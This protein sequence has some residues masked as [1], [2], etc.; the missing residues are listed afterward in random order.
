MSELKKECENVKREEF[1]YPRFRVNDQFIELMTDWNEEFRATSFKASRPVSKS[2]RWLTERTLLK[3]FAPAAVVVNELGNILFIHGQTGMFLEPVPGYHGISNVLKMSRVGLRRELGIALKEAVDQQK[4]IY[5][6]EISIKTLG[7]NLLVNMTVG[8][9]ENSNKEPALYIIIFENGA[10]FQSQGT[11]KDEKYPINLDE[12]MNIQVNKDEYREVLK[13]ERTISYRSQELSEIESQLQTNSEMLEISKRELETFCEVL[14]NAKNDIVMNEKLIEISNENLKT[15]NEKLISDRNEWQSNNL[16]LEVSNEELQRVNEKLALCKSDFEYQNRLLQKASEELKSI[17]EKLVLDKSELEHKEH[18]LSAANEELQRIEERLELGKS[19][20]EDKKNCIKTVEE[21]LRI[22]NERSEI[23]KNELER[24]ALLLTESK[25]KLQSVKDKLVFG[26]SE[27]KNNERLLEKDKEELANL[28]DKLTFIKSELVNQDSLLKAAKDELKIVNEQVGSSRN[29]LRINDNLFEILKNEIETAKAELNSV[30]AE[31]AK[32]NELPE[33]LRQ[34]LE[35]IKSE[36]DTMKIELKQTNDELYSA[37][38]QL[39]R[40]NEEIEKSKLILS[41]LNT[42]LPTTP[43]KVRENN[44]SS[45]VQSLFNDEESRSD[46]PYT[47]LSNNDATIDKVYSLFNDQESVIDNSQMQ[48]RLDKSELTE[49]LSYDKSIKLPGINTMQ[50]HFRDKNETGPAQSS[51][52]TIGSSNIDFEPS[53]LNGENKLY[54]FMVSEENIASNDDAI[55]SG[56]LLANEADFSNQGLF[57]DDHDQSNF[58][59]D[60][61]PTIISQFK[62]EVNSEKMT[63]TLQEWFLMIAKIE[64]EG[65]ELYK[66]FSEFSSGKLKS[67]VLGFAQEEFKHKRLMIDLSSDAQFN[68]IQLNETV[69]MLSQEQVDYVTAYATNVDLSSEKEFLQ[70]ALQLEKN[71]IEIY[72]KQLDIFKV[73]SNEYKRFKNVIEEARKHMVFIVNTLNDLKQTEYSEQIMTMRK[74]GVQDR[75]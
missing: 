62:H 1:N 52:E 34:N 27:L 4:I 68:N 69:A 36:L 24:N 26:Q 11:A 32:E 17:S 6:P 48:N 72:K 59:A 13:L 28:K 51:G 37:N 63:I 9:L 33:L 55:N 15:V 44:L 39:Q 10:K 53:L 2:L 43:T 18:L 71:Y 31:L 58:A 42:E 23:S 40:T 14:E 3:L 7:G 56:E 74:V 12:K 64:E 61:I 45:R 30:R 67:V 65:A 73:D 70:F 8:P 46:N 57:D 75:E 16:L 29:E 60:S 47:L 25:E 20:L 5:T 35:S 49:S 21:E 54:K 19:D 41:S 50:F 66:K 22:V 38:D